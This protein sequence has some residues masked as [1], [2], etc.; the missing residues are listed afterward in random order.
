MTRN[1]THRVEF[2]NE[3]LTQDLTI[4]RKNVSDPDQVFVYQV[5]R[6]G[7]D[8]VYTVTV[9]GADSTTIYSLPLGVYTVTQMNDW[10]W[11][12]GD[13]SQEVSLNENSFAEVTFGDDVTLTRWLDGCSNRIRN[14]NGGQE[15]NDE[16]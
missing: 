12:Y 14:W 7:T 16:E 1:K 11:R 4:T 2:K 5:R 15:G 10:S 6:E 8:E 3:F 9:R 13:I